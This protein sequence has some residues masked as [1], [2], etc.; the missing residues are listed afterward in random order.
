MVMAGFNDGPSDTCNSAKNP[1]PPWTDNAALISKHPE[2]HHYTTREGLE[3]IWRSNSL[4]ATHFANL[5]DSSEMVALKEPLE[6]SLEIPIRRHLLK[7]SRESF[8]IKRAIRKSGGLEATVTQSV[9][10]FIEGNYAVA[11]TGHQ[12]LPLAEP[13]FC[14][15][16]SHAEDHRYERV[17]GLL[18]QWRGYGGRGRYAIVL[19]TMELDKLLAAEWAAHFWV[20][21]ELAEVIYLD[22]ENTLERAFPGLIRESTAM[23]GDML[24]GID[25]KS[26]DRSNLVLEFFNAATLLKHRGFR[27]EREIRIVAMPQTSAVLAQYGRLGELKNWPPLKKTEQLSN[28]KRYLALFDSLALKLPITRIIVGPGRGQLEDAEFA[29]KLV[30]GSV[31]VHIS[32][33]PFIG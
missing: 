15:L 16:C 6:R 8:K 28:S 17:N 18:S 33:T 27:E 20:K 29:K 10:D 24:D 30:S 5:N 26:H 22:D 14:S 25:A 1:L 19:D 2:L 32:E 21:L 12:K 4:W 13:F 23:L 9:R 11:F 31:P 7:R 3:G